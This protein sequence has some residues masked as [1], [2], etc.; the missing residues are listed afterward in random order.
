MEMH[1]EKEINDKYHSWGLRKSWF[2]KGREQL[3]KLREI[4][5]ESNANCRS[6]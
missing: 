3:A 6:L 1:V 2:K 4:N 5:S